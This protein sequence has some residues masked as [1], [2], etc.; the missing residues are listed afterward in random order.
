LPGCA[1]FTSTFVGTLK[2]T[3][4]PS[5]GGVATGTASTQGTS[6]IIG[7]TGDCRSI[8]VGSTSGIGWTNPVT[9]TAGNL[10]FSEQRAGATP[11]CCGESIDFAGA[12][13]GGVISGT[14]TFT[15]RGD[16]GRFG[17]VA[18]PVTLR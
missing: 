15:Q 4:N 14:L 11:T 7:G 2:I 8:P 12:L 18:I 17:A 9:G 3:L 1:S 13:S 10:V 5:S 16:S 6:T